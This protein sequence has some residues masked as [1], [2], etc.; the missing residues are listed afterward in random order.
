MGDIYEKGSAEVLD[1]QFNWTDILATDETV[2]SHT[3]VSDSAALVVDS[4]SEAL[5]V[6][7]Y[8]LSGGAVGTKYT[9][10]CTIV[11]NFGRTYVRSMP[12]EI[13]NK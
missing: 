1:F 12:I 3:V 5:G 9:A 11:T 4:S 7:T 2:T 10:I 8:W 6:V 13:R